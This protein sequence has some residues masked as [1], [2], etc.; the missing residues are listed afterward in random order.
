MFT[1]VKVMQG[2]ATEKFAEVGLFAD[3][4]LAR[5]NNDA[6][7]TKHAI[8]LGA[9]KVEIACMVQH[10]PGEDNIERAVAERKSFGK[11]LDHIDRQTGIGS[12]RRIALAPT[13]GLGSGSRAVTLNPSRARA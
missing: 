6:T 3:H 13:I 2:M 12:K 9:G 8:H 10:S 1:A 4:V 5:S 7:R 11:L